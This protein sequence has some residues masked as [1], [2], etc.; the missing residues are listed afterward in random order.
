MARKSTPGGVPNVTVKVSPS[1]EP[2]GKSE[3]KSEDAAL[4]EEQRIADEAIEQSTAGA[5]TRAIAWIWRIG[6]DGSKAYV[7]AVAPDLV[8]NEFL[9]GNCGGGEYQVDYRRPKKS[10][11][12]EQATTRK[13][14]IDG[15]AKIAPWAAAPGPAAANPP[16]AAPSSTQSMT[17]VMTTGVMTIV[18]SM[19]DASVTNSQLTQ[20]A[21]DRLREPKPEGMT[22]EKVT[23]VAVPFMTA[24]AAI[25]TA[26]I[27][28]PM[29][30]VPDPMATAAA[31]AALTKQKDP[32]ELIAALAPILRPP[33]MPAADASQLGTLIS[34]LKALAD[35]KDTITGGNAGG[36]DTGHPILDTVRD[37]ARAIPEVASAA[38]AAMAA[39]QG[40]PPPP[41]AAGGPGAPAPSNGAPPPVQ[42]TPRAGEPF[43][44]PQALPAV[45]SA[46][47][48]ANGAPAS[49]PTDAPT[50]SPSGSP[51]EDE[52]LTLFL[53][54]ISQKLLPLA[55]RRA[56]PV[57]HAQALL[58][59]YAQFIPQIAAWV[60]TPRCVDDWMR[61]FPEWAPYREW[62][63]KFIDTLDQE[64]HEAPQA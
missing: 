42:A 2:E 54:S 52:M 39:R 28:R 36:I 9:L 26:I 51:T 47:G 50:G 13:F 59:E 40:G 3:D 4:T 18:K 5:I 49:S 46:P 61:E 27:N 37:V 62:V 56:D 55:Q 14:F 41:E 12:T 23:A 38:K 31:L 43:G 35:L 64:T 32:A 7:G 11:G 48:Q 17:D 44:P 57:L 33:P 58:D 29:P 6:K 45:A 1:T 63:T 24:L 16:G 25:A 60:E 19:Q 15:P 34:S 8:T 22:V 53:R 20:A 10:G 30:Q 21:I